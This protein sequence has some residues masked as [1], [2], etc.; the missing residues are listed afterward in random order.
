MGDNDEMGRQKP[1]PKPVPKPADSTPILLQLSRST[2][3]LNLSVGLVRMM[4]GY[5]FGWAVV[6]GYLLFLLA[7]C[8]FWLEPVF[9]R[10]PW[11][12][13][14]GLLAVAFSTAWFSFAFVFVKAPLEVW[15]S[16]RV[17]KYGPG[18]KLHG[19]DWLDRY[20]EVTVNINNPTSGDYDNFDAQVSTDLAI[21]HMFQIGGLGQCKVEG[22]HGAIDPPHWQHM[23]GD[24]PVGAIDDPHWGY[25][26]IPTDKEGKAI[27]PFAGAD[28]TY[29]VRCDKIPANSQLELFGAL[30]A[31]N[32][33]MY[34]K[35]PCL[36]PCRW[37]FFD[38]PKPAKWISV[39]ASYQ[40]SGRK[41]T[42]T[43]GRCGVSTGMVVVC[44][45]Q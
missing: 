3:V 34:A 14:W 5:S 40:T 7:G 6:Q 44:T 31:V 41:R 26:V 9:T 33:H 43:M 17:N 36:V 12:R 19:I 15:A 22:V 4:A 8:E 25:E 1:K 45:A 10:R 29:R 28:W 23:H 37:P 13:Y 27:V 20:S 16:S 18:S 11:I 24:Q 30:V 32:A 38:A 35:P 2:L 42:K 21:N 39:L